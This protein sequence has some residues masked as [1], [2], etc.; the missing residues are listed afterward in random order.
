MRMEKRCLKRVN[1]QDIKNGT[2]TIPSDIIF[3]KNWF[4]IESSQ[5]NS[6]QLLWQLEGVGFAT[7][8]K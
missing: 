4:F 8:E 7:L 6:F 3:I 5:E 1:I 2:I